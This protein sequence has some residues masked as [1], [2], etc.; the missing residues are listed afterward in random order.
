MKYRIT[1]AAVVMC[2]PDVARQ[3]GFIPAT[4]KEIVLDTQD[5]LGRE[6]WFG[7]LSERQKQQQE[8]LSE[9]SWLKIRV[10]ED[11]DPL[12]EI[13][14]FAEAVNLFFRFMADGIRDNC[15]AVRRIEVMV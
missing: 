8:P 10:P 14:K 1:L 6:I 5:G 2:R 12:N 4:D 9:D 15:L 7:Y 11:G 13:H 3:L